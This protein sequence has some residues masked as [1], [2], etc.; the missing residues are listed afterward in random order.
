MILAITSNSSIIIRL[1]SFPKKD[2]RKTTKVSKNSHTI[3][4]IELNKQ[5]QIERPGLLNLKQSREVKLMFV[6]EV[7]KSKRRVLQVFTTWK[8]Q[9]RWRNIVFWRYKI[10]EYLKMMINQPSSTLK[11]EEGTPGSTP[12]IEDLPPGPQCVISLHCKPP[13]LREASPLRCHI[14]QSGAT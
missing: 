8:L 3:K 4:L 13:P 9:L 10:E 12:L 11:V 7:P 14:H 2:Y 5:D 1:I 6:S